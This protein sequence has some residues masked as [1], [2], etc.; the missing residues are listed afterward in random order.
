MTGNSSGM[1]HYA[2][3]IDTLCHGQDEQRNC[4][5]SLGNPADADRCHCVCGGSRS[6]TGC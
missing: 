4:K 5:S 3:D 2:D 6:L 1:G